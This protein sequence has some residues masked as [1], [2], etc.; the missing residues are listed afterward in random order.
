MS[1]FTGDNRPRDR[2]TA[3]AAVIAIHVVLIAI[4]VAGLNVTTVRQAVDR[5][6]TIDI[7]EVLPPP[8]RKPEPR[9]QSAAVGKPA[10]RAEPS[11]VVAPP[12]VVPVPSALPAARVA[13]QGS[14]TSSGAANAG[15][16]TGSSGR[17]GED[18]SR[19]TPARLI[20]NLTRRDY[21][22]I[23]GG[24]LPNGSADAAIVISPSGAVSNCSLIRSSGNPAVDARL[25]PLIQQQMRFRPALDDAG[26]AIDFRFTF[27]ASWAL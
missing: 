5:L 10:P 4:I 9:K 6:Q 23:T 25:C 11:P 21:R 16:G 12:P 18:F 1:S 24:I 22:S 27:H 26:R 2:A 17:G 19:F 7:R 15:S 8:R 14:A 20:R 3:L 13:G